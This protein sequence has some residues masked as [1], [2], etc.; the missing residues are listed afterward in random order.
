VRDN[1][2]EPAERLGLLALPFEFGL[3]LRLAPD[4]GLN[5]FEVKTD[6]HRSGGPSA[7]RLPL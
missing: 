2:Y 3:V 6:G 7:K 4:L 5:R 1:N